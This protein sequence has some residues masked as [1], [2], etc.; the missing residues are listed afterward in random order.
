MRLR[1]PEAA[2]ADPPPFVLVR[3]KEG[4]PTLDGGTLVFRE[5]DV[6]LYRLP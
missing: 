4:V 2:G 3:R 6:A 5:A 1:P